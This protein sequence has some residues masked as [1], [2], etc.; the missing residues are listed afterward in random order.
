MRNLFEAYADRL[1]GDPEDFISDLNEIKSKLE[2]IDVSKFG[3]KLSAEIVEEFIDT[4][5]KQIRMTTM[6]Y[7]LDESTSLN[8][9]YTDERIER[10]L[11]KALSAISDKFKSIIK[12]K[13]ISKEDL[14]EN[15][16]IYYMNGNDGTDFDWIA[17]GRTCEFEI[18]YDNEMGCAKLSVFND[19]TIRGYYWSDKGA[20]RGEEISAGEISEE[21][22]YALAC[23]CLQEA[24]NQNI[25]D[26]DIQEIDWDAEIYTDITD[27]EDEEDSW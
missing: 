20:G 3:A 18:F 8:E 5:D 16:A 9:D 4:I 22:A 7:D 23:L 1:G 11:D 13:D 14:Y 10:E 6:K 17:N 2:E 19:G 21:A 25:Y 15:G 24:D 27:E 12:E 26:S